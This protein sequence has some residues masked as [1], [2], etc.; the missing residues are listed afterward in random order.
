MHILENAIHNDVFAPLRSHGYDLE[1]R[2]T[3]VLVIA[4]SE[5]LTKTITGSMYNIVAELFTLDIEKFDSP[6]RCLNRAAYLRERVNNAGIASQTRPYR[7][8]S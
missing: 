7:R 8:S 6:R 4:L 5:A 1:N 3:K 2:D